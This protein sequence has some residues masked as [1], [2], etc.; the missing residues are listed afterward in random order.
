V[1]TYFETSG[2]VK[3]VVREDGSRAATLLWDQ[4]DAVITSRLTHAEL[5]AALAAAR[6]ARRLSATSHARA[7][8]AADER[9]DQCGIVDVAE[10][11]V[12][13]AG[14]LAESRSLRAYDAVHLASALT[15]V[16]VD[17]VLATWD[18]DLARAAHAEGL[19][20]AGAIQP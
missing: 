2:F 3:L 9:L 19:A 13:S 11:I 8:R 6:R 7:K 1:I 5:W 16:P 15:L 12:R 10:R 4:A 18:A 17:V 20:V 14:D